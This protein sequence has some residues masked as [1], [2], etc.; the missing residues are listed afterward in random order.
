MKGSWV[1]NKPNYKINVSGEIC[2]RRIAG[3]GKAPKPVKPALTHGV[4]TV[5]PIKT[6]GS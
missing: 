3:R 6:T 2:D 1:S 4:D 5:G